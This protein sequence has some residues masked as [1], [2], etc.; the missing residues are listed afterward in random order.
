MN[1]E[2]LIELERLKNK[3]W[4]IMDE[5]AAVDLAI[6]AILKKIRGET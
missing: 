1:A 4:D 2:Q 6:T 3:R 5:L